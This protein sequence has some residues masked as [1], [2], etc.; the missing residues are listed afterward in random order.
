MQC[1]YIY[2]L[3]FKII[4]T[5]FYQIALKKKVLIVDV[6]TKT[7]LYGL[8]FQNYISKYFAFFKILLTSYIVSKIKL[9]NNKCVKG[10]NN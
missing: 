3:H 4:E 9:Y 1:I 6:D 5:S 8:K 10:L 7:S 2:K